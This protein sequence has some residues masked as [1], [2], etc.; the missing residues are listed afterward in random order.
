MI[1][2]LR[3]AMIAASLCAGVCMAL[4]SAWA[5]TPSG[6]N[7]S[8]ELVGQLSKDLSITGKQATGGAG[9]LFGLA[10]TRLKPEEFGQIAKVVPGM[11]GFLKAAPKPKE[12]KGS[13]GSLDSLSSAVPGG[14]SGLGGLAS[15]AGAFKSLGLSPEMVSKFVPVLTKFVEGKGGSK[16]SNLL[17]GALK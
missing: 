13:L 11:D 7:P 1:R 4:G 2:R 14:T 17:A 3:N 9:A 5:E 6:T 10:K 12:K 8:P 16:L 15:A